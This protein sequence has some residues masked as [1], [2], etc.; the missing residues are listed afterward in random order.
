MST[1]RH[2][3]RSHC[4]VHKRPSRFYADADAAI[5]AP[6]VAGALR[7]DSLAADESVKRVHQC[8]PFFGGVIR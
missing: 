8:S 4:T 5:G 6:G 7:L 2:E 1:P 3:P